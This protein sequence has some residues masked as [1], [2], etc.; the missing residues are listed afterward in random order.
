M[1]TSYNQ[2]SCGDILVVTLAPNAEKQI[3][4]TSRN[5]TRISNAE[6]DQVTGF[7]IA[8][9]GAE[10]GIIG[11]NGQIFLN[12]E[13]VNMLNT[14]IKS[15]GF[16]ELLKVSPS[17]LVIGFVESLSNH[18]DS[19]HLHITQT[20][21]SDQKSLQIVSGS[22]NM[23]TG[24]KVVVAQPGT[25]MPSGALIWDGALRGVPSSGMIVSGRELHLPGAPEK[26]GALVLPNDFG[27]IGDVFDF[28]KGAKLYTNGLVDT[29]Y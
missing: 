22:P 21:V 3:V 11:E 23:K 9:V 15:A 25:M 7:N 19:D 17:K 27:E 8:N 18:P 2:K 26:P 13:Q 1:I 4:T 29:N 24:I 16:D 12:E 20:K 5:V 14:T 6:T 28:E 10:L